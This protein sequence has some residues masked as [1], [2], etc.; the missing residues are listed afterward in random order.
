[1]AH[2]VNLCRVVLSC[3]SLKWSLKTSHRGR[4]GG[5]AEG[6]RAGG[7]G[8]EGGVSS[9]SRTPLGARGNMKFH[10]DTTDSREDN[11]H[12]VTSSGH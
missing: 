7:R 5:W 12:S 1:M 2:S 10:V 9:K 11:G 4:G 6:G 8:G 3:L